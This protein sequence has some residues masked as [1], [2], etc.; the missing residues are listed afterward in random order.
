MTHLHVSVWKT[1]HGYLKGRRTVFLFLMEC[2]EFRIVWAQNFDVKHVH[3]FPSSRESTWLQR[4]AR[5]F[6][7]L[8]ARDIKAQ[9]LNAGERMLLL[10]RFLSKH[11]QEEEVAGQEMP[12]RHGSRWMFFFVCPP[13]GFMIICFMAFN[14]GKLERWQEKKAA[15]WTNIFNCDL[16]HAGKSIK[17]RSLHQILTGS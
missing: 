10:A 12:E 1:P 14:Q 7:Y 9:Q 13:L 17:S 8:R 16:D 3:T 11:S 5:L 6:T 15:I 4:K 2:R